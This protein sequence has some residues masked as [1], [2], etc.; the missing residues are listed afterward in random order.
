MPALGL[1]VSATGFAALAIP[2]ASVLPSPPS[3]MLLATPD[4]L[5]L[6]VPQ[7]GVADVALSLP[8]SPAIAGLSF[9]QQVVA[10]EIGAGGAF[11]SF[12][13]TNAVLATVGSYQ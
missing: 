8:N 4:L 9:R 5:Q 11:T 3:C 1:A 13:S 6:H 7:A 10:I 12:T 2:L